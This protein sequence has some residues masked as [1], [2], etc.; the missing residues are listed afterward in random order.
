MKRK[1]LHVLATLL[2]FASWIAL[3]GACLLAPLSM[4]AMLS[5]SIHRLRALETK[6]E[7]ESIETWDALRPVSEFVGN[8]S[9]VVLLLSTL[10]FVGFILALKTKPTNKEIVEQAVPP[11]S[12]RAG[13]LED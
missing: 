13:E 7:P 4:R 9:N 5:A 3:C 6:L 10:M 12:D 8:S 2:V 1:F 11:K